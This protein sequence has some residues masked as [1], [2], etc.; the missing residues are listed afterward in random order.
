M[1]VAQECVF[2]LATALFIAVGRKNLWLDRENIWKRIR[3]GN[4][5]WNDCWWES[6]PPY[7]GCRICGS[8]VALLPGTFFEQ[9]LLYNVRDILNFPFPRIF[10]T[11]LSQGH[12]P[13]LICSF[14][15]CIFRQILL[16]A[17]IDSI[18]QWRPPKYI[19]NCIAKFN[20][21]HLL[22]YKCW[23]STWVY[24]GVSGFCQKISDFKVMGF[25]ST[26][27]VV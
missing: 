7:Q 13:I 2:Y 26:F 15:Y 3:L 23:C 19:L 18:S 27:G 21:Q 16:A 8:M 22:L 9:A 20:K 12:Q 25:C 24:D 6:L 5:P 11:F 1:R 14:N 10:W 4:I 17:S